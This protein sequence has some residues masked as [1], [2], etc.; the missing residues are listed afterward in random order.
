MS[1]ETVFMKA[2]NLHRVC[3]ITGTDGSV[4]QAEP[5]G[6]YTSPRNHACYL[7][8]QISE[9]EG[10]QELEQ[11]D[12]T[13]VKLLEATFKP[14]QDYDPFDKMRYPVMHYSIPT[15]DGR[16][17]WGEKPAIDKSASFLRPYIE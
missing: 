1:A 13:R 7:C 17:R 10:W 9:P 14:R 2:G 5:Y 4:A 3:E 12:V 6:I 11:R 16:Q 8:Y 15:H